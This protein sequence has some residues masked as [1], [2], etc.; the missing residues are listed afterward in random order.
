MTCRQ[1]AVQCHGIFVVRKKQTNAR[2]WIQPPL[3]TWHLANAGKYLGRG[4]AGEVYAADWGGLAV[5]I[6]VPAESS[7]VSFDEACSLLQHEEEVYQRLH[8]RPEGSA[9]EAG[10]DRHPQ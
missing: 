7:D 5:A 3:N 8:S 10:I 4:A 6:K 9:G 2:W 1:T